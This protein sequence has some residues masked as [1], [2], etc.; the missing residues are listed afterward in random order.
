M[1][2][3]LRQSR[4]RSRAGP[5]QQ[6]LQV[7]IGVSP[8]I[9]AFCLFLI[10]WPLWV[11]FVRARFFF[12]EKYSVLEIRLPKE[13]VKSPAAMELFLTALHQT[14]GEGNWYDKYVLGKTRAWFSLEMVSI[15]GQ[16]H[17]FHLDAKQLEEF[18]RVEPVCA[19]SWGRGS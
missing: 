5:T 18:Y 16:I 6:I 3:L 9:L 1:M 19:V 10:F 17:F 4:R 2:H 15:E 11:H 14:G 7:V 8:I 12:K 13:T